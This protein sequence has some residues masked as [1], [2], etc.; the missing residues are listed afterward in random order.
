MSLVDEL[1]IET[2]V[3]ELR[4]ADAFRIWDVAG[5]LWT[6]MTVA[7]PGLALSEVQPNQQVF[8][9]ETIQMSVQVGTCRLASRGPSAVR[10]VISSA[11]SFC[12]TVVRH[13]NVQTFTRAGF[14]IISAKKFGSASEAMTFARPSAG[15][16]SS[17]F[18][19][20]SKETGFVHGTRVETETSGIFAVLKVEDRKISV[21]IPWNAA[22]YVRAFKE[23]KPTVVS[24]TDF[25]TIGLVEYESFDAGEWTKQAHRAIRRYWE[26]L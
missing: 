16:Y 3:L 5:A 15:A 19:D 2:A 7:F 23:E 18:L 8:E 17:R 25:Y 9:A 21:A 12:K 14:R 13:L 1:E 26:G 22:A 11:N 20:G 10:E 6:E 4:Y 24:D